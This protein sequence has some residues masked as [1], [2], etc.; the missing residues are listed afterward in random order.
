MTTVHAR[1]FNLNILLGGIHAL[2]KDLPSTHV[3]VEKISCSEL[4]RD[5]AHII[6]DKIFVPK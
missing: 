4:A 3:P 5:A 2:F 1:P 6:S